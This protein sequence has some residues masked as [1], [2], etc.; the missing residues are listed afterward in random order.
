MGWKKEYKK[1]QKE[2][3]KKASIFDYSDGE[4][5]FIEWVRSN[6][7]VNF[8]TADNLLFMV[9]KYND[10]T[11][12]LL[13]VQQ[14]P[15]KLD[16]GFVWEFENI[17]LKETFSSYPC[18][19]YF[20]N[21]YDYLSLKKDSYVA[22]L[23]ITALSKFTYYTT[24]KFWKVFN[25]Y[26]SNKNIN[27]FPLLRI[28][29]VMQRT[30]I[31]AIEGIIQKALM[32][33]EGIEV[34]P[35][36]QHLLVEELVDLGDEFTYHWSRMLDQVVDLTF[37]TYRFEEEYGQTFTG[38]YTNYSENDPEEDFEDF[39]EKTKTLVFNDEVNDAFSYFGLTK[40]DSPTEFKKVYRKL[41]KVFHP[42][43]NPNIEAANEMKKINMF[44]TIIEQYY[45]KY[46]IT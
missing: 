19:S 20:K 36:K 43:V 3:Q 30:S 23:I 12:E 31:D 40:M 6:E 34:V 2:Q 21:T 25:R 27:D 22:T 26:F 15:D 8:W 37:D 13:S 5:S 33:V 14:L 4:S 45:D 42:D 7:D 38:S 28:F 16:N 24:E 10:D 44:K 32:L 41:A 46:E 17:N 9:G 1:F 29:E 39:F 35:Y 11:K 18:V